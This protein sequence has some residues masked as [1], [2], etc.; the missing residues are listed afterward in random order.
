VEFR[1]S[2]D[3]QEWRACVGHCFEGT[4]QVEHIAQV[5]KGF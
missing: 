3:F 4:P 1:G 2:A 5:L